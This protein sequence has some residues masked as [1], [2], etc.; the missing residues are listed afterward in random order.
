MAV[1]SLQD[2][3]PPFSMHV[4]FAASSVSVARHG[5]RTWLRDL[6]GTSE[7][8]EDARVV[9][10]ELVANSVRHARPLPD[11]TLLISWRVA[12]RG[13]EVAVTDGGGNTLPR[14]VRAPS[15]A[16]AGRGIAM[17]DTLSVAW[18]AERTPAR[19]TVHAV[20]ALA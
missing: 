7:Q 10:S 4:P 17:V 8:V 2:A 11:G 19:S 20:L 13:V 6:G 3:P 1:G 14:K 5:L 9:I 16:I 12:R 18:W 15:S